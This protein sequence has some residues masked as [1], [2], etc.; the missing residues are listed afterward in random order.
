M[1]QRQLFMSITE[2]Q[3]NLVQTTFKQVVPIADTAAELFYG[4]LFEIAPSVRVMFKGDMKEQG[5]KL[6]MLLSVAVNGLDHLDTIVPAIQDLGRR[7]V[8]YGVTQDQYMVVADALLWTLDK[9]LGEAFTSEV[10]E[11]WTAVYMLV[12]NTAIAAAYEPNPS[13]N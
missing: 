12:A 10:K 9:G 1:Q 8:T 11:A 2:Q 3:K 7:H 4:R 5:R 6:M 13:A